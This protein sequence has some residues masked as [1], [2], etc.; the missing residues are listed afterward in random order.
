MNCDFCGETMI[1]VT[2]D[3]KTIAY[4]YCLGCGSEEPVLPKP[5]TEAEKQ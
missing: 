5:S 1:R 4:Y 3:G 2:K